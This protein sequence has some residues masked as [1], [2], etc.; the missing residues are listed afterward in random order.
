M[1]SLS[2]YWA[3]H[4]VATSTLGQ[5]HMFVPRFLYLMIK[6]ILIRF[7][8][9]NIL[10]GLPSGDEIYENMHSVSKLQLHCA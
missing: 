7:L 3:C 2:Q 6:A 9:M 5:K 10:M 4:N 8:Y 1:C